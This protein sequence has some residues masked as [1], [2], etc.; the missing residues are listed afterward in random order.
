MLISKSDDGEIIA[1]VV[2]LWGGDLAR[3][4]SSRGGKEA[5]MI[6][7]NALKKK[8]SS[9]VTTPDGPRGPVYE[10]QAGTILLSQFTQ[11]EIV[12][13]TFSADRYWTL[14]S[15]DKFIIPKPFAKIAV[16]FGEPYIVP[17]K[18]SEE[19]KELQR[20]KMQSAMLEQNREVDEFIAQK[21]SKKKD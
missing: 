8:N 6:L 17:R 20:Q 18:L 10:F 16:S 7:N 19:E 3:G 5:L 11:S 4:S 2:G 21:N 12:P 14:R 15:W 9:I 1:R 13:I